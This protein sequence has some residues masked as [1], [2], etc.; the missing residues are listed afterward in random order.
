MKIY[1]YLVVLYVVCSQHFKEENAAKEAKLTDQSHL[2]AD[3]QHHVWCL[4]LNEK[5]NQES[6]AL[7]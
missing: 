7:R 4:E 3:Q 5:F 6:A 1:V 2:D